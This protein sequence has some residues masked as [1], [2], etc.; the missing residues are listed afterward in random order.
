MFTGRVLS[1]EAWQALG[2]W[3]DRT[4]I[5]LVLSEV[6]SGFGRSGR[7][8][9]WLNGAEAEADVVLWW[10]GGQIGHIF[11]RPQVFVSKPLTLIS[12]WDGDELSASR[13]LWQLYATQN[14]MEQNLEI[15]AQA[16][17]EILMRH[18]KAECIRGL[19]LYYTVQSGKSTKIKEALKTNN[20][21]V[22]TLGDRLCFAPPISSSLSDLQTFDHK[23]S[24]VLASLT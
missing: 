20:V 21:Q 24:Q 23:L 6:A 5:P 2:T 1:D 9:W 12:T 8:F 14:N 19:G 16:F 17:L 10:A 15:I 18:F 11:C 4:G 7:G 3:R 22:Q 13:I